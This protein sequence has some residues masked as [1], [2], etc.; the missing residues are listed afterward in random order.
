MTNVVNMREDIDSIE[1]DELNVGDV[2]ESCGK[3]YIKYYDDDLGDTFALQIYPADSVQFH[4]SCSF[5][6][7]ELVS[8]RQC[9]IIIE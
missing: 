4:T 7:N 3:I 9:K 5:S 8:K 1:F 2:F 6:D